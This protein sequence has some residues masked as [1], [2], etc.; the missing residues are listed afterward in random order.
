MR[1]LTKDEKANLS[2]TVDEKTKVSTVVHTVKENRTTDV[3][4]ELKWHFDFTGVTFKQ[5]LEIAT[6]WVCIKMQADWRKA[7]DRMKAEKWDNVTF[8]VVDILAERR[9][10]ADPKTRV[11][12]AA[13][14][15]SKEDREAFIKQLQEME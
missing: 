3:R 12:N 7:A 5:L 8:K 9:R 14:K 4:T 10:Q 2:L 1:K 15:M 6:R 13:M 11:L